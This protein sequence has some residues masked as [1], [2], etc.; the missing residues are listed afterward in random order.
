[1]MDVKVRQASEFVAKGHQV[2]LIV[3]IPRHQIRRLEN[4][5]SLSTEEKLS[6]VKVSEFLHPPFKC[7]DAPYSHDFSPTP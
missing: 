1:M 7:S 2:T 5:R 6:T 3:R 4:S